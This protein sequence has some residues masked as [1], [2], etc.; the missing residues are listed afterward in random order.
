MSH[1][2]WSMVHLLEYVQG[3]M[4]CT[5]HYLLI[6]L[7][8]TALFN[9]VRS[10]T[11]KCTLVY[12]VSLKNMFRL[13]GLWCMKVDIHMVIGNCHSRISRTWQYLLRSPVWMYFNS[14]NT[15]F[16]FNSR[17]WHAVMHLE[18]TGYIKSYVVHVLTYNSIFDTI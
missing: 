12:A 4:S 17:Y 9:P 2:S 16:L 5:W 7:G 18:C 8:G 15:N 1:A 14:L 3:F 6:P 13:C 10:Y 11:W